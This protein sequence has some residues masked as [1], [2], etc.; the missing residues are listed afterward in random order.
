MSKSPTEFG[1]LTFGCV[2]KRWRLKWAGFRRHAEPLCFAFP[3]LAEDGEGGL[4]AARG[5][6]SAGVFRD[7][8]FEIVFLCCVQIWEWTM[9]ISES[10]LAAMGVLPVTQL[11][12][13]SNAAWIIQQ[14]SFRDID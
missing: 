7:Y 9:L 3:P 4:L 1:P 13:E 14:I 6:L 10:V 8:V 11:E 2:R 5:R 12:Q